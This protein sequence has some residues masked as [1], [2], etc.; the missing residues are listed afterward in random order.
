M[1]QLL[2]EFMREW[3]IDDNLIYKKAAINQAIFVRD[4]LG[5]GILSSIPI[6]VVSM[7]RSKS[8]HLPVY[9]AKLR[10]GIEIMMRENFY[11]WKLSVKIP[12]SY[13]A[14]P[15]NYLPEDCITEGYGGPEEK[16]PSCY[17]EGFPEEWSFDAFNPDAPGKQFTVETS[18]NYRLYV[19]LHRLKHAYPYL[20]FDPETDKRSVE[21]VAEAIEKLYDDNGFNKFE[22]E[23]MGDR[24]WKRRLMSPYDIIW[25]TYYALEQAE[26]KANNGEYVSITKISENPKE[27]AEHIL[28]FPEV[29]AILLSEEFC[30]N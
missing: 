28:R 6:F 26:R 5:T 11:D 2:L 7:H 17:L 18:S 4:N 12:E 27:F 10:N 8:V 19:L 16:I 22:T 13:P 3:D 21:E 30:Y 24:E 9:Y 23:N 14:L 29:H 15:A 25:R 1:K 20:E